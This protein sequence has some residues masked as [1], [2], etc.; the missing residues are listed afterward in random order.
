MSSSDLKSQKKAV[1]KHFL[2]VRSNISD[3]AIHRANQ[4][5]FESVIELEQ[6]KSAKTIHIYASMEE[7][8]EVDT[9]Q[10]IKQSLEV[11]KKVLLPVMQKDAKLI[12][13]EIDS[14]NSLKKNSWGVPEPVDQSPAENS[15]P[16]VIFVPMV[17]GDLEKNRIGYGKGY[18]DRFLKSVSGTKIGLLF[19]KQL[20]T[21]KLPTEPFDVALDLLI[22]E[23]QMIA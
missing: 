3:Q 14:I 22:T 18:Y 10:L 20:S 6:F 4:Q 11:G 16:D 21:K 7:R 8:N 23:N 1:R 12:H 19:E 17:A 13:C 5:I 15:N 9:F 2:Q